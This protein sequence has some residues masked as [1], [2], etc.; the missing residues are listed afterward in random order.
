[1]EKLR[2]S[3]VHL[4]DYKS[5]RLEKLSKIGASVDAGLIPFEK[6]TENNIDFLVVHHG[7]FGL[8]LCLL[9]GVNYQ[10]IKMHGPKLSGLFGPSPLDCH[11][12]LGNNA[13]IAKKLNLVQCGTFLNYEGSMIL[14]YLPNLR[15]SV[16]N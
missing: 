5:I 7:I 4:T 3:L 6:A 2:T 14:V 8:P 12:E 16:K 1:M 13:V 9:P 11:D 15:F 10:K